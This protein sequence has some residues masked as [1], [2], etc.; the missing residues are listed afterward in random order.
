MAHEIET[1]PDYKAENRQELERAFDELLET[2]ETS[3]V[4]D[5][6]DI[7]SESIPC[8]ITMKT[9]EVKP[10]LLELTGDLHLG[11]YKEGEIH[12]ILSETDSN[13]EI[14]S[15]SYTLYSL[16]KGKSTIH[17]LSAVLVTRPYSR[18]GIGG[19]LVD[20]DEDIMSALGKKFNAHTKITEIV[21]HVS[22][23]TKGKDLFWTTNQF[24]PREDWQ[25]VDQGD[26]T[27]YVK[28]IPVSPASVAGKTT[29]RS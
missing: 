2:I 14:A 24:E 29:E 27:E 22:D 18:L 23:N 17:T 28:A 1:S 3:R 9:G 8:K 15:R 20:R 4:D 6:I 5:Q 13:Q 26:Y 21:M 25:K 16:G 11:N 7:V 12:V 19:S 10:A